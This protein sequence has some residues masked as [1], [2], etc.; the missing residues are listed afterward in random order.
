MRRDAAGGSG[1]SRRG[2]AAKARQLAL[3]LARPPRV[4]DARRRRKRGR[5]KKATAGVPHVRRVVLDG[6]TPVH[7]TLRVVRGLPSLRKRKHFRVVRDALRAGNERDDF[8][9][10]EHSV[11][12]DHVHLVLEADDTR[13]LARGVQGLCIRLARRLNAHLRRAGRFF[14]D[15]YHA[16]ALRSP[17]EVRNVIRYVLANGKNH[18]ARRAEVWHPD[19]VDPCSSA[20]HFGGWSRP[21]WPSRAG[22][23]DHGPPRDELAVRVTVD[24]R[25]WLL[26]EGWLRA[27]GRLDPARIPG[28]A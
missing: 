13:A 17:R 2:A 9:L 20:L 5:P 24:A 19:A 21:V 14:A 6:R 28:R 3:P 23:S 18:G 27:G 12:G 8:R 16:R 7:V 26:S 22:P 4:Q 1:T 11:Q 25:T 15:R 10:V